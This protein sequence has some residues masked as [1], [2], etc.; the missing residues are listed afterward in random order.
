M[1][2]SA[3]ITESQKLGGKGFQ[4]AGLVFFHF[5]CFK[6]NQVDFQAA[7]LLF[8]IYMGIKQSVLLRNS[9]NK[10]TIRHIYYVTHKIVTFSVPYVKCQRSNNVGKAL[11]A[12]EVPAGTQKHQHEEFFHSGLSMELIFKLVVP[13]ILDCAA[14]PNS[15]QQLWLEF[16]WTTENRNL[17]SS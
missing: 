12:H 5:L 2:R 3:T 15:A 17:S 10:V 4:E 13:G 1:W 11:S 6:N 8:Q 9:A 7:L 14:L 16:S